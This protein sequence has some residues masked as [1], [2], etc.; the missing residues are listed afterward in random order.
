MLERV[1]AFREQDLEG[2]ISGKAYAPGH[3]VE[4]HDVDAMLGVVTRDENVSLGVVTTTSDF[5]PGVY[6]DEALKRFM[7][8]RLDLRPRVGLIDLLTKLSEK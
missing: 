8:H 6:K 2:W 5:A 1:A 4:R 3:V 7:P